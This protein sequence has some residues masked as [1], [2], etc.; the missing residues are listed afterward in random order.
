M[1][2]ALRRRFSF[3]R[4]EPAFGSEAFSQHL[5]EAGVEEELADRIIKALTVLNTAIRD[6]RSIS[7]LGLHGL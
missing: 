6:D 3:V 2:Y 4:L 7:M 1:D 5:I